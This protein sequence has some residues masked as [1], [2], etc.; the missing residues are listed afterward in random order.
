MFEVTLIVLQISMSNKLLFF[1]VTKTFTVLKQNKNTSLV[2][3]VRQQKRTK[4]V[5]N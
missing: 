4:H 5:Y 1:V 2:I 3:L